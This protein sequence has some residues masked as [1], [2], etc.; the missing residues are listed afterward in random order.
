MNSQTNFVTSIDVDSLKYTYSMGKNNRPRIEVSHG[1]QR[2]RFQTCPDEST[3]RHIAPYGVN[4]PREGMGNVNGPRMLKVTIANPELLEFIQKLDERNI[5]EAEEQSE[6][7]FGKKQD[8]AMVEANY[9]PL[10][11][12]NREGKY[13]LRTKIKI[14]TDDPDVKSYPTNVWRMYRSTKRPSEGMEHDVPNKLMYSQGKYTD[15]SAG[16]QCVLLCEPYMYVV[17]K[18]AWGMS[19]VVNDVLTWECATR[20]LGSF[21]FSPGT[22]LEEIEM[23]QYLKEQQEALDEDCGRGGVVLMDH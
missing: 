1:D 10:L 12:Q 7:W 18:R 16:S 21:S 17:N 19:L 13:L 6:L 4:E 8:R 3:D 20:G 22:Q 5:A 2:L 11:E 23:D 15:I 9:T 14:P